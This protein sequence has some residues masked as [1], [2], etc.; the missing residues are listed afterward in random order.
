MGYL[1]NGLSLRTLREAN[2]RRLPKFKDAKGNIAHKN[3]DGSD[4]SS[5]EWLQATVGEL[6]ELA[7]ILK[8]VRRGDFNENDVKKDIEDEFADILI[9]LDIWA[10]QH[11]V[12]LSRVVERKFNEVSRRVGADVF[13][14]VDDWQSYD[15]KG[16]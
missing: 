10:M 6:G 5:A 11:K 8:K 3:A 9:Y 2:K 16:N 15:P 14:D 4:W 13:I 7:N 1:T 12:D